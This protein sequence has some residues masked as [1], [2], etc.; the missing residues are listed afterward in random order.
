MDQSDSKFKYNSAEI[1][2]KLQL[3]QAM[4]TD[5]VQ[6]LQ[7]DEVQLSNLDDHDGLAPWSSASKALENPSANAVSGESSL[8]VDV[9]D[10]MQANTRQP[11]PIAVERPGRTL[12]TGGASQGTN[13]EPS[14]R[15]KVSLL[16]DFKQ[17]PALKQEIELGSAGRR[18]YGAQAEAAL[19][20][21]TPSLSTSRESLYEGAEAAVHSQEVSYDHDVGQ[22]PPLFLTS[23]MKAEP[24][25]VPLIE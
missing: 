11:V 12:F 7:D 24:G 6:V 18:T 16:S 15:L 2:S 23:R 13:L 22:T 5:R 25:Q 9:Q 10:V 17:E 19:P 20:S 4:A 3:L 8:R 21:L 14:L 1:S